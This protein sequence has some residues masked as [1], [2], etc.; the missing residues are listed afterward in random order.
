MILTEKNNAPSLAPSC[1]DLQ[2]LLLKYRAFK[3]N[4]VIFMADLIHFLLKP[5][6]DRDDFYFILNKSY[7]MI[8]GKA[9]VQNLS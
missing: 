3:E 8:S 2:A 1:N 9:V 7:T 5:S 4:D 6:S